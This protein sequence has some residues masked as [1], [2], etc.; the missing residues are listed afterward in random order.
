MDS[1]AESSCQCGK[2]EVDLFDLPPT[3]V[4]L[5][6][7][8]Y[9]KVN[10]REVSDQHSIK[11]DYTADNGV[12]LDLSHSY[13]TIEAKIQGASGTNKKVGPINFWGHSLF[14]QVDLC[15][16]G[17]LITSSTK[18]YPYEAFVSTLLS[19]GRE[20]KKSHLELAGYTKDTG[21]MD[22]NKTK[23]GEGENA[24][25][26]ARAKRV[27][28]GQT[29]TLLMR[30]CLALFQQERLL[31]SGTEISMT[32]IPS[33]SAFNLMSP[34]ANKYKTKITGM[35]FH[36]RQVNLLPS[37]M[38][39][40]AKQ[41]ESKSVQ[42]PLR[43]LVTTTKTL[44]TGVRLCDEELFKDQKPRRIF[45]CMTTE[46][47]RSGALDKNPFNFQHFNLQE[48]KLQSGNELIN[49][50]ILTPDFDN[51]DYALS[52]FSLFSNTGNF[53]G[54][55]GLDVTYS[56]YKSGYAIFV[57]DLTPDL[58]DGEHLSIVKRGIIRLNMRFKA[59]ITETVTIF[60]VAEMENVL[61]IGSRGQVIKNWV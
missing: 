14:D 13:F 16:N 33:S 56:D 45:I 59:P 55:Q 6:N 54:D 39:S 10:P 2:S 1:I 60:A 5:Q 9:L 7:G 46:A 12:F 53:L 15:L 48:I 28:Q 47:A 25:L 27:S 20:A 38:T 23:D 58:D 26:V 3:Q 34:E 50:Q 43:R 8:S 32:F 21:N 49:G 24:G 40:I 11:F 51:N 57:F 30:P 52:Y 44:N 37:L 4:A 31:P 35:T 29:I 19:Y 42:Y 41:R 18:S 17:Q 36:V 22:D 61:Q